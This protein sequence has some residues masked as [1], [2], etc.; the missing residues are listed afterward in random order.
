ME[1]CIVNKQLADGLVTTNLESSLLTATLGGLGWCCWSWP[2]M[3]LTLFKV[4]EML[5]AFAAE[6]VLE[7]L[8]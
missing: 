8:I 4:L 7:F 6:A 5:L 2:N 3:E 1:S